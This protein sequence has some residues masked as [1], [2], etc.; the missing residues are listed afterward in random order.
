MATS[1]VSHSHN[2]YATA[3]SPFQSA[4]IPSKPRSSS[5]YQIVTD[6]IIEQLENG[7]IPWHRPWHTAFPKS[8]RSL[9]EYRGINVLLLASQGHS[10]PYWLTFNQATQ[11][12]GHIKQGEHSTFVTFWKRSPYKTHNAETGEDETRQGFLLRYYRVFNLCQTE[13]IAE[14][15]GLSTAGEFSRVPNLEQCE[16]IVNGMRL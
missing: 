16:A 5:V 8:L 2:C 13:G 4:V 3:V 15:L 6:A 14:K 9:R 1:N 12:G 11:L 7:V 10:S